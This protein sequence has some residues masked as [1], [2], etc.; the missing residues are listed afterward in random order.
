M[1]SECDDD[2]DDDDDGGGG[3][4]VTEMD[5]EVELC[6]GKEP[7]INSATGRQFDCDHE[8]C[9]TDSYCHR[10][11]HQPARCCLGGTSVCPSVSL[12]VCLSLCPS[13]CL[14]VC[15]Q[16]ANTHR[17]ITRHTHFSAFSRHCVTV[18]L[19]SVVS[20]SYLLEVT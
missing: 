7:L 3:G 8:Q 5:I 19:C 1:T 11:P 17:V 4:G 15:L 18:L 20:V 9:P 10:V 6:D 16:S 14:S 13:M 12:S 2:D